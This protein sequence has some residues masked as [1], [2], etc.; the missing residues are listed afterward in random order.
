MRDVYGLQN[1][2]PESLTRFENRFHISV[3]VV[4]A[5]WEKRKTNEERKKE[6]EEER[7][8]GE[9]EEKREARIRPGRAAG[10]LLLRELSE[11]ARSRN[12]QV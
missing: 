1:C 8:K 5:A 12:P 2:S 7:K 6:R 10:R 9:G 4:A 3:R 11:Y